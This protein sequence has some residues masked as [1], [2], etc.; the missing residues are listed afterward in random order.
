M[1]KTA[2]LF[3]SKRGVRCGRASSFRRFVLAAVVM[4]LAVVQA[5]VAQNIGSI[6]Q[7]VK[8]AAPYNTAWFGIYPQEFYRTVYAVMESF[9]TQPPAGPFKIVAADNKEWNGGDLPAKPPRNYASIF[10]VTPLKW[11]I[12]SDDAEGILL[13]SEGNVD[14]QAYN[15]ATGWDDHW[16][17]STLRNWFTTDFLNGQS[18]NLIPSVYKGSIATSNPGHND[19]I[20][21]IFNPLELNTP[22][23]TTSQPADAT[24]ARTPYFTTAE[25]TAVVLSSL[26]NPTMGGNNDNEATTDYIYLPAADII[27]KVYPT[28]TDRTSM[29]SRYVTSHTNTS[30]G[31]DDWLTRTHSSFSMRGYVTAFKQGAGTRATVSVAKKAAVRPALHLD[32]NK[33]LTVSQSKPSGIST[34]FTATS[35]TPSNTLKL[36]LVDATLPTFAAGTALA[37]VNGFIPVGSTLALECNGGSNVAGSFISCLLEDA[38]GIKYY[39]KAAACTGST[40]TVTLNFTGVTPG[41]YA[42]KVFNEITNATDKPDYA[43]TPTTIDIYIA[44]GSL[45][46]PVINTAETLSAGFEGTAYTDTVKL[47]AAG[48]PAPKFTITAGSLP[49][50]LSL[51]VNTGRISGTPAAGTDGVHTFK[52][53][54]QNPAGSSEEQFTLTVYRIVPPE[55]ATQQSDLILTGAHQGSLSIP[56]SFQFQLNPGTGQPYVKFSKTGGNLP[57][58]LTLDE[59][60]TLHGTPTTVET[61]NFT[62]CAETEGTHD[63]RSYTVSILTSNPLELVEPVFVTTGLGA[64]AQVRENTPFTEITIQVTGSQFI[65]VQYDP[66]T[67]PTGM[68]FDPYTRKITGMPIQGTAGAYNLKL[69]AK[70]PATKPANPSGPDSVGIVYPL[71]VLQANVPIIT[72]PSP[73]PSA[74]QGLPYGEKIATDMPATLSLN[75]MLPLGIVFT[76]TDSLVG[77]PTVPGTYTFTIK[78]TGAEGYSVKT[79]T[80]EVQAPLP[81]PVVDAIPPLPEGTIGVGYTGATLTATN[82]PTSWAWTGAPA[83]LTLNDAGVISGT[84]TG[85]P[86]A[87]TVGITASNAFATSASVA[88]TIVVRQSPLTVAPTLVSELPDAIEGSSYNA[89]VFVFNRPDIVWTIASG[90]LPHG[91]TFEDGVI[92]GTPTGSQ[93]KYAF[94]VRAAS[95]TGMFEPVTRELT[96][97]VISYTEDGR[98]RKVTL[99]PVARA[100]TDPVPNSY[101]VKTGDDFGFVVTPADGLHFVP[102]VTTSR[103]VIPDAEGV[104]VTPNADGTYTIIVKEIREDIVINVIPQSTMPVESAEKVWSVGKR[105]YILASTTTEAKVHNLAGTLVKVIPLKAGETS[106]TP[107]AS[108]I[109]VI[110]LHKGAVFKVIVK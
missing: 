33:V 99:E 26:I 61:Q 91:L 69:W 53:K 21:T 23:I 41:T 25:K 4:F 80:L 104:I 44:G 78:A 70:N 94:T 52:V 60:G 66:A 57:A 95:A 19:L 1:I 17:S 55:I 45:A 109:Y 62:I 40:A 49:A 30:D 32:R 9:P 82:S 13:L 31:D 68:T 105:L 63:Y 7:A 11:R 35:F 107:L 88:A 71:T 38:A 100:S 79:F 86:G 2:Y 27:E 81:A 102:E 24:N 74:G 97:W 85:Q 34:T 10:Y 8:A 37:P 101:H 98:S 6:S 84:P 46:A 20:G 93:G 12:V 58:G 103:T 75:G 48:S 54:A 29:N 72:T 96:I 14:I 87:Y 51:N 106:V 39:T 65:D 42:L 89:N 47:S 16:A 108:G 92:G 22:N 59:D 67:F 83:G 77:T 36:T 110:E 28:E 3:N 90:L 18:D 15:S 56:Y 43:T 76:P 5:S 73:L 50:G 64:S